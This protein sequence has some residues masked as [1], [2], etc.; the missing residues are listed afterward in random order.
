MNYIYD[1]MEEQITELHIA[2]LFGLA[3]VVQDLAVYQDVNQQTAR[4]WTPLA[5]AAYGA[6]DTVIRLLLAKYKANSNLQDKYGTSPLHLAAFYGHKSSAQ[7]LLEVGEAAPCTRDLDDR[8]PLYLAVE[9]GHVEIARLFFD[10]FDVDSDSKFPRDVLLCT[11]VA[12]GH[13]KLV[14]LILLQPN[15]NPDF[16]DPNLGYYAERTPLSW[17]ATRDDGTISGASTSRSD[18]GS[19]D[20]DFEAV[21][22]LL[23]KTGRVDVNAKATANFHDLD[24]ETPYEHEHEQDQTPL[25]VATKSKACLGIVRLLLENGADVNARSKDDT[26]LSNAMKYGGGEEL[27]TLLLE[28]GAIPL[29]ELM[30]DR[31]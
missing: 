12:Q 10:K 16:S 15:I 27:V 13:E 29:G 2:S 17:A 5:F 20:V 21:V 8:T 30:E 25:L 1:P 18:G 24:F 31:E 26:P 4:G 22:D 28:Y 19:G 23:L 14:E 11:A 6:H 9:R 7:L 3:T